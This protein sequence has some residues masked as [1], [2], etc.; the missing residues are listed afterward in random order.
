MKKKP[1]KVKIKR[2]K[3]IRKKTEIVDHKR[4]V[5]D[6]KVP[7]KKILTTEDIDEL[8]DREERGEKEPNVEEKL[9]RSGIVYF[10]S[11][12][13]GYNE[14]IMRDVLSSLA[15]VGR[16]RLVKNKRYDKDAKFTEG[17]VE[18]VSKRKAKQVVSLLSGQTVGGKHK[19]AARDAVWSCK[20]LHG[21]KWIHLMEQLQYENKVEAQRLRAERFKVK[22][23]AEFF[24]A[25]VEKGEEIKKLEEKVLK[26]G[27]LWDKY[28]RQVNQ[29]QS[30]QKPRE[31]DQIS[32]DRNLMKLIFDRED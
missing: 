26:K 6:I 1:E 10:S 16:I 11:I 21:F 7:E 32:G 30:I 12:P 5:R 14:R 29:R 27:G 17:W 25:A 3:P 19:S 22:K 28:Q 24:S 9:K 8:L 20:Y 13:P 31:E 15:E 23:Q 18:F 4:D 2:L